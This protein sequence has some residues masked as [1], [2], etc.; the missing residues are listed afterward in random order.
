MVAE[1]V[2]MI[3]VRKRPVKIRGKDHLEACLG[4][5]LVES[6]TELGFGRVVEENI[7]PV[8][9]EVERLVEAGKDTEQVEE[10]DAFH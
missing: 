5:E 3:H 2:G 1:I 4:K 8:A 6:D 7:E 10:G 9:A